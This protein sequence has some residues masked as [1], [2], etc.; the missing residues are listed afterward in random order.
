M[1]I[2]VWNG[3]YL[4]SF[5]CAV[6]V[7]GLLVVGWWGEGGLWGVWTCFEGGGDVLCGGG[8]REIECGIML[9]NYYMVYLQREKC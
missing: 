2:V 7:L 6:V 3:G 1:C 9:Y 5:F 8:R 4:P